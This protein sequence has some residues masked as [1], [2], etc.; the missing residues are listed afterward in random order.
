M[1][2]VPVKV[3]CSNSKKEFR[4]HVMLDCWSQGTFINTD[5]ARKLKA[6]AV[7]TTNKIKAL[8]AEESQE[9][10]A[11]SGFKVSKPSGQSMWVDLP[12]IYT[13]DDLPVGDEDV[14]TPEKIKKWKYL[15]RIADEIT[16]GQCISI[17]LLIGG[18]GSKALYP[19][20]VI[21]S[22]Q[23]GPYAFK[24]LLGWYIV[25]TIG[26]TT[27][28]TKMASNQISVQEKVSRNVASHYF[29]MKTEVRDIGIEQS[30]TEDVFSRV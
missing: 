15:E 27:F 26:V 18:N 8:D 19:L 28:D 12:V 25:G 23:G 22:E 1:C 30:V 13:K 5:L 3:K 10:E 4:T 2:V 7:Q 14:A 11:V 20:E 21:P 29:A 17:G 24:T 9:T 6:E 16:L